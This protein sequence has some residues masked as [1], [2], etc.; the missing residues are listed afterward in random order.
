MGV[1]ETGWSGFDVQDKKDAKL[2]N[3]FRCRGRCRWSDSV[4]RKNIGVKKIGR[5]Q[6]LFFWDCCCCFF[7]HLESVLKPPSFSVT[8]M[9]RCLR[10]CGLNNTELL[11]R[12]SIG[13]Y[14]CL[15]LSRTRKG[16]RAP[17]S[18]HNAHALS[19]EPAERGD[20]QGQRERKKG[21]WE[22]T[23]KGTIYGWEDEMDE[24]ES[25]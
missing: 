9:R 11:Q 18:L 3:T 4:R 13:P 15:R 22:R 25:K 19:D 5:W 20:C 17:I 24:I 12:G 10:C 21:D 16:A 14:T 8:L 7:G 2:E 1:L 23:E 6:F